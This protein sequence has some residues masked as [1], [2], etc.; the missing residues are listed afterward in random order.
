MKIQS[1]NILIATVLFLCASLGL[2]KHSVGKKKGGNI[3]GLENVLY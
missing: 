2:Y 3:I 1:G